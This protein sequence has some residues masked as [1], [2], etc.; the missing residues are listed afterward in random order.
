MGAKIQN[1][2]CSDFEPGENGEATRSLTYERMQSFGF[3]SATIK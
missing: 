1:L 2:I 3:T